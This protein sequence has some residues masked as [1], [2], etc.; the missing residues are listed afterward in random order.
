MGDP[1][2]VRTQIA[3][4]MEETQARKATRREWLL[5]GAMAAL[6]LVAMGSFL[7]R[8]R[9]GKGCDFLAFW[10]AGR[11]VLEHGTRLDNSLLYR[12]LPS[13]DAAWVLF[14]WMPLVVAAVVY[15]VFSCATWVGL[16][17]AVR[18]YLL[19]EVAAA[20]RRRVV[21]LAALL[22]I[23]FAMDHLMLGAFHILMLWLLVAGLGR[24]MRGSTFSG[25]GLLGAAIWLKLLPL[26]AVP[27]LLLKRQWKA[28]GL[29]VAAAVVLDVGLSM[30][31]FGPS[32]AWNTHVE[33]WQGHA[34]GDLRSLL[35][36]PAAIP[37]QRDRNQS[38]AAVLRRNLT[39]MGIDPTDARKHGM[40]EPIA[41]LR[42]RQVKIVYLGAAGL[43]AAAL[44]WFWRRP[45]RDVSEDQGAIEIATVCLATLWFSPI[46]FSYHPIVALPAMAILVG[47]RQ[48]GRRRNAALIVWVAATVLLAVPQARFVGEM[49]WASGLVGLAL[50]RVCA[51]TTPTLPM[52]AR[53]LS[54]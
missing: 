29:S 53:R 51:T 31:A 50:V 36:E 44:A 28:A 40:S 48:P 49:L 41:D 42:S 10:A 43:L 8:V 16:L 3:G 6:I 32:G 2:A 23:V 33:W 45:A 39:H 12:Y 34:V 21:L 38:L 52:P 11:Q 4:L 19:P 27:Y 17:R 20:D 35:T 15:Y 7:L 5:A 14:G 1:V 46:L 54:F 22:T 37:D 30:A 13:V 47:H 25:A 18:M 26:V 24:V 9:D